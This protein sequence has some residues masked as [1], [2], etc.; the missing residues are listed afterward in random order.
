MSFFGRGIFAMMEQQSPKAQ[1]QARSAMALVALLAFFA[2]LVAPPVLLGL[3]AGWA[4]FDAMQAHLPQINFQIAHP[5]TLY[6]PSTRA[7]QVPGSHIF[8]GWIAILSG[9]SHIDQATPII[10]LV[11]ALFGFGFIA[12]CW[13]IVQR[14]IANRWHAAVLVLPIAC[15]TYVISSAIWVTTDDGALLFYA[16]T[17]YGV[18]WRPKNSVLA[19]VS[20]TLLVLWR[21]IYFPVVGVYALSAAHAGRNVTLRDI[22]SSAAAIIPPALTVAYFYVLWGGF[23]PPGF[24]NVDKFTLNLSLTLHAT[25]LTGLFAFAYA[26][27]LSRLLR[28]VDRSMVSLAVGTAVAAAAVLWLAAPSDYNFPGERWGS[29]V[30][31][32]ARFTPVFAHRSLV[33][34]PLA[35]IGTAAL[36]IMLVHALQN[37]YF[38]AAAAM[39]LLYFV[40]YSCQYFAFQRYIEPPILLTLAIFCAR[41]G[42]LQRID[43]IGPLTLAAVSGSISIARIYGL[44]GHLPT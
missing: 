35:M 22:A 42:N 9:Y 7:P 5:F 24:Q 19:G 10:R 31:Y 38:P 16:L 20:A 1:Q 43:L 11:N 15:S 27:T 44:A 29:V 33:V 37:R 13:L 39:L 40:A 36:A 6:N 25:A 21:Q 34:L 41:I 28:A 3:N 30:W 12:T 26:P 2:L 17:L 18:L 32:L 23:T 4:A 8:L 14:L